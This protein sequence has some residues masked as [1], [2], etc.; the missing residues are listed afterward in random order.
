MLKA[1]LG[2]G[3]GVLGATLVAVLG[4]LRAGKRISRAVAS[5][6]QPGLASEQKSE[7]AEIGFAR[8]QLEVAGSALRESESRFR[9][10]FESAPVPMGHVAHDGTMLALN[11]RFQRVF[12]YCLEELPTVEDWWTRAYPD[13]AYR[14]E[15]RESWNSAM[16][17]AA[18]AG[19]EPPPSERRVIRS[20]GAERIVQISNIVTPEGV[21]ATFLDVTETRLAEA[22][23]KLWAEAFEHAQLGLAIADPRTNEFLAVNPAFA[24]QHGYAQG[25]LVGLPVMT[26]FPEDI[27][28]QVR[29]Q[30]VE[31]DEHGHGVFESEHLSKDGRRFPVLLDITVLRDE[32]GHPVNRFAY[33]LD[34]TERKRTEKQLWE[35]QA[36]ALEHQRR[37]RVAALNQM[38]DANAARRQAELSL[39]ALRES[40][41]RLKLFIE[42]APASLA[43]FDE[44]MRYL[45]VSRRWLDD[46]GL[47]DQDLTGRSHYEVFPEIGETWKAAHRRGL[48]GE[49][50]RSDE[51]RF[52]RQDGRVQWLRWEVRPWYSTEGTVGGVVIFSEDVTDRKRSEQALRLSEEKFAVAFSQNAAA[53]AL[54][55]LENGVFVDVNETWSTLTGYSKAEA[56][57]HS[58]RSMTIWPTAEAASRFVEELKAAGSLRWEQEFLTKS[59]TPFVTQLSAQLLTVGSER[60]ILS[61]LVDITGRKRAEEEVRR[62]NAD[63]EKRVVERTDELTAANQEL[64]SFAYAVSHDL[65]APLRAMSGFSQALV[66]DFGGQL[67][68]DATVYL[69]QIDAASRKMSELIDG[70]LSLSRTTRGELRRDAV[71]LTEMAERLLAEFGRREPGRRVATAVECGLT[72]RGDART[73][74]AALSNLLDNAWKYTAKRAGAAI[75]V[76]EEERGGRRWFCIAD[77]GAGF[78]MAHAKRLF[79]PFQRM[80]RQ[81]EF[82]GIGI[83]LATVQRI[84]RRHGGEIE[85][86]A[87]PGRGATFRFTLSGAAA[88]PLGVE[89]RTS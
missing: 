83:G 1:G 4:G 40:E 28:A 14:D 41:E 37:A 7:I 17:G 74:E 5:L 81:D 73:L 47:Q 63:L 30:I 72:A 58:A 44:G 50:I 77:N 76:Y 49:V 43:M 26:V 8:S 10:L 80:H 69:A 85:A 60:M 64:E 52:E 82:S 34:L 6:A 84:I 9:R 65:R 89:E 87:E 68:G 3:L 57:G 55:R 35:A 62:L 59:G 46:Y 88:D 61:T 42:H 45:A 2:L 20:D 27:R 29:E 31:V 32:A 53:I 54:T 86:T 66:E 33:A 19:T 23:L 56:I 75:R 15:V 11:A 24:G 51:D 13:A 18:A 22:R 16:R 78:D 21:L 38:Q 25:E 70:I 12:G 39:S 48:A 36:A 67:Q 71:D 79:Q